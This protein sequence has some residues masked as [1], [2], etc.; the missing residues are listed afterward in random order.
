L[1]SGTWELAPYEELSPITNAQRVSG[2]ENYP[3]VE[4]LTWYAY[5]VPGGRNQ[6]FPDLRYVH[7]YVVRSSVEIPKTFNGASFQLTFEMLNLINT[8]FINGQKVGDFDIVEGQWQVDATPYLK[9]GQKNEI[10]LVIK[11]TYYAMELEQEPISPQKYYPDRLFQNNQGVTNRFDYPAAN[12]HSETGI[13]DVARLEVSRGPVMV[14]D[15]FVKPFPITKGV[16]EFETTVISHAKNPVQAGISQSI[17][18]WPE[19]EI[20]GSPITNEITLN[21]EDTL[22]ISL[23]SDPYTL[24][25]TYDPALYEL[26]TDLV[27]NGKVIDRQITR[28]GNREWEIRGNQFFLNGVQ[29]HLRA[30]LTHYSGGSGGKQ[31]AE[32]AMKELEEIGVNMFRRRFQ[33]NW[34]GMKPRETLAFMDEQGMPVRQNAATF[35]GQVASYKLVEGSGTERTARKDL[36][37]RWRAQILNGVNARKNNPSIFI[38]ELDNELVYINARN[39]GLLDQV[40]PEFTKTSDAVMAFDPTRATVIGGGAALSDESLPTYGIHYFEVDDRKYPAEAYTAEKSLQM[41]GS[42]EKG[43][44]WPVNFEKKPIF[45]SETAFLSGRNGAGFAAV[46]GEVTFLGKRQAR[47]AAGKI[48]SWLAEGYRWKGLGAVHFWFNK[49]FT[50]GSY[51]YAWQPVALLRNQ[52]GNTFGSGEAVS[53]SLR[54]YND[55]PDQRP[56]TAKWSLELN[57]ESAERES[58]TFNVAPGTF[59]PWD[60][61]FNIPKVSERSPGILRLTVNRDGEEVFNHGID[62]EIVP[63]P[64]TDTAKIDGPLLVWDPEG[65]TLAL[66]EVQEAEPVEAEF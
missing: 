60:I 61:T 17:R 30:D 11:D 18:T 46:G 66:A 8:L 38:W 36:F 52:W 58:K 27:V 42:G 54:L 51:T 5:T 24:W 48:A 14:T 56:L 64:T 55:L 41:E 15:T 57:G 10:L 22:K 40:E 29:Q 44:V 12:G 35:D 43:R 6:Q 2:A 16:I 45:L 49:G 1:L 47:P 28:F 23:P 21:G 34:F 25:W 33:D 37:E 4:G 20:V 9:A 7:R 32:K 62:I 26:V 13:L 31:G 65:S 19:G 50:D 53:R 63:E 3:D 59:E 39:F